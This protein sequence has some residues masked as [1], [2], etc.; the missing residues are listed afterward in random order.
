M[1]AR[2]ATVTFAH[3]PIELE[4]LPEIGA[5]LHRLRAFGHD[6]LRTPDDPSAHLRDP[7]RWGAYVMAPWCNRIAATPMTVDGRLVALAPNFEDGTAIHGQV[8][9]APWT[10]G[11]DGSF[12]VHGGGDAWPWP[13]EC[14]LRV[15]IVDAVVTLELSVT[16]LAQTPM[17]AGIG[18]HPWFRRPLDVRIDAAQVLPSNSDPAATIEPVSR[19]LDLRV[20][21]PMPDDLDAAWLGLGDP[22]VELRWP[23][24]GVVAAM[25]ARSDAGLC[26]VAASP[27][28]LDAVAIE[29][30][31]HAPHGLRRFLNG[32]PG[33]LVPL[34]RH[35]TMRLTMRLAFRR[36]ST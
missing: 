12:S 17:P 34:A 28:G 2:L 32:E 13:Y 27:S 15:A 21:R 18:L 7:F 26:L 10:P 36:T 24:L 14:R 31:T 8:H 1:V 4:L 16:N 33:G 30:Q 20:M 9:S 35:A 23:T 22:P 25:R 6:L 5:R 19:S 3:G 29:P 11:P